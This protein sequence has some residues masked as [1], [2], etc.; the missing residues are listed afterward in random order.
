MS[1]WCLR[2]RIENGEAEEDVEFVR[3]SAQRRV[4]SDSRQQVLNLRQRGTGVAAS[5][6]RNMQYPGTDPV[7][8]S[9]SPSHCWPQGVWVCCR[10]TQPSGLPFQ[11]FLSFLFDKEG[12]S[13]HYPP[14]CAGKTASEHVKGT[15]AASQVLCLCQTYQQPAGRGAFLPP[16]PLHRHVASNMGK[17]VGVQVWEASS[18]STWHLHPA[19]P[20]DCCFLSVKASYGMGNPFR[21]P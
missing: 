6:P 3:V 1:F 19:R 21:V 17:S 5:G 20:S 16:P 4:C 15:P 7:L 11:S 2:S 9:A 18:L 8:L 12:Q 10:W 14:Q 13:E